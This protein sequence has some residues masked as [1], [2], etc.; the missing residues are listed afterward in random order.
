MNI[1]VLALIVLVIATTMTMTGRGGGNF[2]VLALAL[3]G[4]EMHQAATTG[5][6]ILIASSFTATILFGKQKITDWKLVLIIGSMTMVSAF[7]GGFF[8]DIFND[9]WLKIIFSVFI[10]IASLLMLKPMKKELK[11]VNKFTLT[12]TSDKGTYYINLMLVVP[13]VLITGFISGMVGISGGSFL[14][15]LM[16]LAI[17]VPTHIAIGTSTTLVLFTASAGFLGHLSTGHFD[18]SFALPLA[19]AGLIGGLIGAKLTPRIKSKNLKLV[20][21]LT[22]LIAAAIMILRTIFVS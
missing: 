15:P 17:R 20:F 8:S 4:I 21:A 14:V 19:L 10:S 2:Y 13:V 12:L 5:Q 6:F 18:F 11:P 16:I 22:S 1:W 3:A 9:T 7:L